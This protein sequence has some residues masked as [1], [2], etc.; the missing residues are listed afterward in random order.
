[1]KILLVLGLLILT[2][3][4]HASKELLQKHG[5]TGCHTI[6]L[7]LVGPAFKDVAIK[8]RGQ[9]GNVDYL[10][11]KIKNGGK[12][13]WGQVPMLPNPKLTEAESKQLAAYILQL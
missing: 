6:N 10:A 1:M 12:G 2:P 13:V 8:Y 7:K 5:C 9:R 11:G 4:A 3:T